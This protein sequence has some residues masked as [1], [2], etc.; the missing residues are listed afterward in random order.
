VLASLNHP[1]IAAIHSLEEAAGSRFL[2]LELVEGETLAERIQRGALPID[3]ALT[4]GKN[5]CDALE[6]AHEKGIVHRDLKPGNVKITPEGQVKVLDFGLA[7]ALDNAAANP[8]LSNSPT[9]SMAATNAGIILGTAAYMSPEQAKGRAVDRRA[10]IFAFGCVLYEMLTG[11]PAFDG[12]DV[13]EILGRVV[14]A[15]PDW[16]RLPAGTPPPIRQLLRRALRKDPRQRLGDIRD[17]RIEIEEAGMRA[18]EIVAP[19]PARRTRPAWIASLA[20]AALVIVALAIPA[21][22]HLRET[23]EPE[24]RLEINTPSTTAPFEFALS[25]NG[26]YLVFVANGDG[27]QQLWLRALDKTEAQ[28]LSGTDGAE[29]PFWSPDSRSIGFFASS[30]LYRVDIAGGPPQALAAAPRGF[31]GT[32]NADGTILFAPSNLVPL[33]RV[34]ASGG[35]PVPVT[36]LVPGQGRQLLPQ[37]LPDGRHFLFLTAVINP[38]VQ[39]IYLASLDGGE[40][41]RLTAADTAGAFLPPDRLIFIRQDALVSRKLDIA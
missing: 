27:R 10:D 17:A 1:H 26:R 8:P 11:R 29:L 20:V 2:V 5:I 39:G 14:T 9:L 22:R 18:A 21:V 31:G 28:P 4:I 35:D 3:E 6:A 34:A 36:R 24:M 37:F 23:A 16:N 19:A 38:E 25:P 32:W 12:E 41:K 30:K 13:T 40:P 15:E 7:K 33:A